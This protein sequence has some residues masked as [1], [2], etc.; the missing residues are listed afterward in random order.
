MSFLN[1]GV[2]Y[3]PI[4][5]VTF[6]CA[7]LEAFLSVLNIACCA[8]FEELLCVYEGGVDD[9]DVVWEVVVLEAEAHGRGRRLF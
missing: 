1:H 2:A 6:L 3:G 7:R 4:L 5:Y 9:D 8:A